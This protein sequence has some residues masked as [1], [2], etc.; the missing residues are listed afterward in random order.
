MKK[1]R[2]WIESTSNLHCL[3]LRSKLEFKSCHLITSTNIPL[4]QL[5]S[6]Q[7]ELP[8]KQVPFAVI[9]PLNAQGCSSWLIEHG[10]Q[11]PWV[12]WEGQLVWKDMVTHQWATHLET[13]KQLLFKPSPFLENHIEEIEGSLSKNK[14]PWQV[15]D[16]GCGAGRDVGWILT[17]EGQWRA[18]AIDYLSGSM[19]R[20]ETIVRNLNVDQYMN[21]L[22][23]A[24]LMP[25]GQWKLI[26]NTWF[27]RRPAIT[28]TS[29][30]EQ[31]PRPFQAFYNTL[32][33]TAKAKFDLILNI[34]FLSRPFLNQVPELLNEG[35]YFLIS[36]FVHDP[37][38]FEYKQPKP[39]LRLELNEIRRFFE[40]IKDMEIIYDVID[41]SEDGRPLN[42]ILVRKKEKSSA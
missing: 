9:E 29:T 36:H 12:F 6:R 26:A 24:K 32:L 17:R 40:N 16:I 7:A 14:S 5:E 21:T 27:P 2:A 3:D 33:P 22:A 10:W 31:E 38:R 34:R 13:K 35:G 41:K 20:T 28:V 42:S 1:L 8:P 18:S 37:T 30:D 25:D 23:Q 11:I 4:S 39:S 19:D 15:L